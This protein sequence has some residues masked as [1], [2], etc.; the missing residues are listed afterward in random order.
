[1]AARNPDERDA[2]LALR[3][4]H[5]NRLRTAVGWYRIHD[6]LHTGDPIAM[7]AD[8]T[9]AYITARADGKDVAIICDKWEIADAINRRL[10]DTYT[11]A[12]TPGVRVA[13]DQQVR[14]GD[15]ILSRHNDAT[16]DVRPGPRHPR[17]G[18]VDQVRNGNR[19]RVVGIDPTR[20][21][22]A[23]ERLSDKARAVFE[24]E[25]VSAHVT[26]GY[27]ATVHSAQGITVGDTDTAGVCYAILSEH[28]TRAMA[29]VAMTRGKDENHA[30]IYQPITGEADHEHATPMAGLEIHRLRRGNNHAAAHY[31][32]MILANDDRPRTMHAEAE[33]TQAHLLPP[34]IADL[35]ERN[36]Q[37]RANRRQTWRQHTAAERAREAAYQRII[38]AAEQSN[39]RSR[40][41]HGYR[42]EL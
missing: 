37:R 11:A 22:I 3:S 6:R 26:L 23:A 2:S 15:V 41:D 24:R 14:V 30:F 25:Y 35:L 39:D 29:Y 13:R 10:H 4:G 20:G 42:L 32:R 12:D 9:Q 8:A 21:R 40:S 31:F 27:A 16:V 5:G 19:W 33:R 18:R 1:V 17:G 38:S 28:A 36:E 7:A 34:V